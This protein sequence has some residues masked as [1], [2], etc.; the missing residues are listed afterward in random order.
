MNFE[1]PEIGH[2]VYDDINLQL[3]LVTDV[4]YL[5]N[6]DIYLVQIEWFLDG[7]SYRRDYNVSGTK[8]NSVIDSIRLC[9]YT[10]LRDAYRKLKG[11]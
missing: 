2:L 5:L 9:T 1:K 10:E 11:E 3:G 4:A 7:M 6:R 8:S